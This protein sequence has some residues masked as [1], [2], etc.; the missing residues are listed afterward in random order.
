M[1]KLLLSL[2]LLAGFMV[3]TKAE[4]QD[5]YTA[6]LRMERELNYICSVTI[7]ARYGSDAYYD[8]RDYYDRRFY[9][10]GLDW[11]YLTAAQITEF[12]AR[13][14]P[15][16]TRCR[17]RGLVSALLWGCIRDYEDGYY[18]DWQHR[19]PHHKPHHEYRPHFTHHS[20]NYHHVAPPKPHH[21]EPKK[22]HHVEPPKPHHAEPK[23]PH[24]VEPPKPHHAEPKKP[25][26]EPKKPASKAEPKKPAPK[27]EPKKPAP[28]AE[29]KKPAPKDLPQPNDRP[30]DRPEGPHRW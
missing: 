6:R 23:K 8:C 1:K 19:H 4:A 25:H 11:D 29:P 16:I 26:V 14:N 24:H 3:T 21:A 17:N 13:T 15:Y 7:G 5:Y 2:A 30:G 20:A 28:K 10:Y 18:R 9:D 22:P 27:A 12:L